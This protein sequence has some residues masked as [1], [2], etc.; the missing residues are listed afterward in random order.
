MSNNSWTQLIKKIAREEHAA[1]RPCNTFVGKIVNASPV[2]ISIGQQIVLSREFIT[3][4]DFYRDYD[5]EI[6]T[7]D[8][9]VSGKIRNALKNGDKVV[10]IRQE[11]GQR[12]TVIGRVDNDS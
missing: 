3:L 7:P 12:Y 8:G 1:S 4:P 5:V 10:L 6:K 11:G 2:K 9:I